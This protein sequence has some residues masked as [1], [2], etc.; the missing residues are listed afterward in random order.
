MCPKYQ[1]AARAEDF[2]V[3]SIDKVPRY[4]V[5]HLVVVSYLVL[6]LSSCYVCSY[7]QCSM[8][9]GLLPSRLAKDAGRRV[10]YSLF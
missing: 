1:Y 10:Y 2:I 3:C 6:S 7:G 8:A 4:G 5:Q 9:V